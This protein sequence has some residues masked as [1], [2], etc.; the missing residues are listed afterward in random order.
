MCG[1]IFKCFLI[2]LVRVNNEISLNEYL[3]YDDGHNVF[4][5]EML[6]FRIL[7]FVLYRNNALNL[8]KL[9]NKKVCIPQLSAVKN[10]P[11]HFLE[12]FF[13]VTFFIESNESKSSTFTSMAIRISRGVHIFQNSTLCINDKALTGLW[14]CICHQLSHIVQRL[15]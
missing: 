10:S 12:G 9:A 1:W 13:S 6:V 3:T 15:V 11:I 2:K 14:E 4:S 5:A 7:P 8:C